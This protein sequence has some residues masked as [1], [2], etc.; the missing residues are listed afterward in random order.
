MNE[1]EKRRAKK[2]N[3]RNIVNTSSIETEAVNR[4]LLEGL[5]VTN[6]QA[7]RIYYQLKANK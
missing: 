2:T 3:I 1:I 7:K 6:S 5:V 4:L